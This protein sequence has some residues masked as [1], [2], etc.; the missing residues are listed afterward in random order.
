M[1][2]TKAKDLAGNAVGGLDTSAIKDFKSTPI[3]IDAAYAQS[4]NIFAKGADKLKG[5]FNDDFVGDTIQGVTTGTLLGALQQ[6][7]E[8]VGG[9][10][11]LP[12]APVMEAAQGNYIQQVGA[13][14][15][16]AAGLPRIPTFQELSQQTLY[17]T[18]SP[19]YLSQF[20]QP[21]ATPRMG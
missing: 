8:D 10:G 21:L 12:G 3:D 6:E 2:D 20:Y 11:R 4:K 19:N 13:S 9:Y 17:G 1:M 14:A 16:A 5:Y 15:M 7:P 18:G